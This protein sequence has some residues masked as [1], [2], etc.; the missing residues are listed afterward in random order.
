MKRIRANPTVSKPFD[1]RFRQVNGGRCSL[2]ILLNERNQFDSFRWIPE[3]DK[4]TRAIQPRVYYPSEYTD[5]HYAHVR[6][7]VLASTGCQTIKSPRRFLEVQKDSE[8]IHPTT[9]SKMLVKN[10]S[11]PNKIL[12]DGVMRLLDDLDL[13]PDSRLVLILAWKLRAATQCEFTRDEFMNGLTEL[14]CDSIDKLKAKLPTL[15]HELR[16]TAKFKDFYQF[17][18]NY[19]RNPGQ[20]GLDLDMALAYWN[21]VLQGRFR[22]LNL[23]C[24]FLQE[25][26]KRSIPK[27]TWNLLLDFALM[28][29][30]DM[31]NYDEEGAWPVLI[32]DFVEYARPIVTGQPTQV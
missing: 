19:A 22:L 13:S 16:D 20:K 7:S 4:F 31:S 8:D 21:I 26:H 2:S 6:T 18:F 30:E 15:E 11:E 14:G 32:D 9:L 24:Q 12:V 29:N 1:K 27:D 28:I 5:P 25:H 17:T 3:T 23:W 10:A